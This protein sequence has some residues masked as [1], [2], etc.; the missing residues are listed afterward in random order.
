MKTAV[1][2]PDFVRSTASEVPVWPIAALLIFFALLWFEVVHHLSN[3]WTFNAQYSYGWAVP[4]LAAFLLWQRWPE[5]PPPS[6]PESRRSSPIALIIFCALLF[7]PI[8]FVAEANPD[9]RLLSWAFAV[10]AVAISLGLVFLIGGRPWLR[11]FAFPFCFLL[12]AVP[13]PAQ[14]EQ[15]VIQALMRAVTA[16]NVSVLNA[17]GIPALQHG[18]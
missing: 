16:I 13:W 12:V 17:V 1:A 4:F 2:R 15:T 5:R 10:S 14:L 8:R 18:T 11:H 7:F 9:W 6:P 3:E